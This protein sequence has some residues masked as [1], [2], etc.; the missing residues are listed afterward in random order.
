MQIHIDIN[1]RDVQ[2]GLADIRSRGGNL[3][4]LMQD[5]GEDIA[6][7]V[8]GNFAA[9]GRPEAWKPSARSRRD[10]GKP[11]S[12]TGR[13]RRSITV[14]SD[15]TSAQVG[16]NVKYARIHQFGGTIHHKARTL[17]FKNKGGFLSRA[18]AA[19]RK[20]AVRIGFGRAHDITIP[21][22]PFLV[23]TDG[24]LRRIE[25]IAE[26]FIREGADHAR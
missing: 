24:D 11:L 12:D 15:R 22:R 18:A 13:L 17:A 14:E 25:R 3:Q 20:T 2:K 26:A 1:D 8:E 9:G 4:P 16:T 10:A 19:R 6:R 23:L 5:I 7:V 21:A